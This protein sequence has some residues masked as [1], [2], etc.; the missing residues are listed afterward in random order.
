MRSSRRSAELKPNVAIW[1]TAESQMEQSMKN[2]DVIA[3]QYY[4]DVANLMALDGFPIKPTLPERGQ[5][6]GLRIL[7]SV[8][9]LSDKV[10]RRPSS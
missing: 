1:W 8:E 9:S 4:L 2:G 7:V 10:E 3:G 5:S 6:A